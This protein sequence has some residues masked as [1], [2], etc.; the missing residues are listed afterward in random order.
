MNTVITGAT[1]GIGKAIAIAFAKEGYNLFLCARTQQDLEAL[2]SE[3][4][5]SHP[6]IK[7]H[8]MAVD[9]SI[10]QA[11][12]AFAETI[13]S[14]WNQI[15][16]LVNN[17]GVWMPDT[18]LKQEQEGVLEK[19]IETNL[20]S[21]YYLT[22]HLL[23]SMVA[24][25]KGHIF[26]ICSVASLQYYSN[27]ASYSISKFALLGYTKALREELKPYNIKVTAV[28]PGATRTNAWEG[29]EVADSR[30]MQSEDI[31]KAIVGVLQLSETTVVEEILMRP[32]LG[33]L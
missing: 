7:V 8:I 28:L 23:L 31:A 32:Q 21:A 19:L 30:L 15:D 3:I 9:M 2:Q 10:R 11:V 17:A 25:K 16:I 4:S 1:K 6:S 14:T 20:Y 26:N 29:V 18:L 13:Q 22:Q 27:S 33:D 5:D 24:H 12:I